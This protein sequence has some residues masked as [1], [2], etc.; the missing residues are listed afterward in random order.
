LFA[1]ARFLPPPLTPPPKGGEFWEGPNY[2]YLPL[3]GGGEVGVEVLPRVF[4]P[5]PRDEEKNIDTPD[6]L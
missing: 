5:Y 1:N 6:A 3:D 4:L 2:K